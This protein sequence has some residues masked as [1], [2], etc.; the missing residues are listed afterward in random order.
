MRRW[1]M[2]ALLLFCPAIAHAQIVRGTV[3]DEATGAPVKAADLK[4]LTANGQR[5]S[6]VASDDAGRFE[7]VL[8]HG[9]T[10]YIQI[11]RIG[12]SAAKSAALVAKSGEM[13]ELN[14]KLSPN[15]VAVSG[16]EVVAHKPV[17]WRLRGFYDRASA[18]RNSGLGHI[19]TRT[20]LEKHSI[21]MPSQILR[22]VGARP[23][24][25]CSGIKAY[26]DNVPVLWDDVDLLVSPEDLEGVEIYRDTDIPADLFAFSRLDD[27]TAPC[28]LVMFWRKPYAEL[29]AR[30]KLPI[31]PAR[32]FRTVGFI[33]A[34]VVGNILIWR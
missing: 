4:L 20:D 2:V 11:D 16:V 9:K 18:Y 34:I 6:R 23:E 21:S 14:V 1:Y 17:D 27:M 24:M 30:P 7:M 5:I 25:Y 15:A 31:T 12:Y 33:A 32:A 19:Y 29:N 10:V 13:L 3:T 8:P 28:M 26:I 22:G